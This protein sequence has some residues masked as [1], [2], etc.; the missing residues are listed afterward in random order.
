MK[1]F[2]IMFGVACVVVIAGYFLI[3]RPFLVPFYECLKNEEDF[4]QQIVL[5]AEDGYEVAREYMEQQ[6]SLNIDDEEVAHKLSEINTQL[7]EFGSESWITI[8]TIM[9]RPPEPPTYVWE[10]EFIIN[11]CLESM[12]ITG[13]INQ[14]GEGNHYYSSYRNVDGEDE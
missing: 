6:D 5:I 3:I 1:I 14:D 2:W 12:E 7:E 8:V 13:S 11:D 9:N 10:Y 4:N